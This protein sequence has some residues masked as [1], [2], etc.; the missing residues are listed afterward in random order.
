M[1]HVKVILVRPENAGNVGAVARAMANF[2][3]SRLV[4][5]RPEADHRGNE[6]ISRARHALDVLEEAEVVDSLEEAGCDWLVA[7]T[8]KLGSDENIPRL[9][10]QPWQL[11]GRLTGMRKTAGI[12]FGPE[13]RGLLNDEVRL[14]DA[15]LSIPTSDEYPVLN[16]SHAV[17]ILLYE[18][19]V[20]RQGK[21]ERYT[22]V[23]AKD[24]E[25]LY[26]LV[27]EVLDKT[28]FPTDDKRETQKRVW[29]RVLGKSFLT[30]REAFSIMGFFKKLLRR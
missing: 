28:S 7:T 14:C 19:K 24:K 27:D 1:Q 17:A 6:A 10:L 26:G 2:G 23:G 4:L 8:G 18:L 12:V 20:A 30:R 13:S 25:V 29:K 16:L 3:F 22:P 9:A 15:I 11:A 21:V 5:V